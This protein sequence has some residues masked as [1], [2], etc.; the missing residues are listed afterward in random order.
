M[1]WKESRGEEAEYY[2]D[3]FRYVTPKEFDFDVY[4]GPPFHWQ[5]D[6][7]WVMTVEAMLFYLPAFMSLVVRDIERSY[8]L[9]LTIMG[10]LRSYPPKGH[11]IRGWL[12]YSLEQESYT[13]PQEQYWKS[14]SSTHIRCLREWFVLNVDLSQNEH[15]VCMTKKERLIVAEFLDILERLQ[16]DDFCMVPDS[17]W[18]HSVRSIL[19]DHSLSNRLGAKNKN[20]I[21]DLIRLIDLAEQKYPQCFPRK[22]IQSINDQLNREISEF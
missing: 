16:A 22:S 18:I 8:F 11:S 7:L 10:T 6:A 20:D 4:E 15:I 12:K 1:F 17:P 19:L 5:G 13:G 3:K 21:L 14:A 2:I 9:W